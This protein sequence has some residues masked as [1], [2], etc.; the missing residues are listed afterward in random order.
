MAGMATHAVSLLVLVFDPEGHHQFACVALLANLSGRRFEQVRHGRLMGCV[1]PHALGGCHRPVHDGVLGSDSLVAF[2]ADRRGEFGDPRRAGDAHVNLV[3]GM[4]GPALAL[5]VGLVQE[6]HRL[7]GRATA[8]RS[9]GGRHAIKKERHRLVPPSGRA[10]EENCQRHTQ[11]RGDNNLITQPRPVHKVP[12]PSRLPQARSRLYLV[13]PGLAGG[14]VGMK[15]GCV[16]GAVV[17]DSVPACT[18]PRAAERS[19]TFLPG[20]KCPTA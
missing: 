18:C 1:T 9:S 11:Y 5:R 16:A 7:A 2:Q 3:T 10:P 20:F 4:A 19:A 6:V 14:A 8:L 15:S 17:G 12:T 13:A